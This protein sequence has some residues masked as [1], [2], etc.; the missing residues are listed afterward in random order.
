[1]T[2]GCSIRSRN[3]ERFG[4]IKNGNGK[5]LENAMNKARVVMLQ[6]CLTISLIALGSLPVIANPGQNSQVAPA[7]AVVFFDVS[8]LPARIDEPRLKRRDQEFVLE[9]A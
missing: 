6:S 8:D 7:N 1:M 2:I 5:L 3:R 4:T 9:C